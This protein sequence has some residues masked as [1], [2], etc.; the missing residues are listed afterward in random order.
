MFVSGFSN[1]NL[2]CGENLSKDPSISDV[3]NLYRAQIANN[4]KAR[5]IDYGYANQITIDLNL[6]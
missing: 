1:K 2:S 3:I 6:F 4:L 5:L